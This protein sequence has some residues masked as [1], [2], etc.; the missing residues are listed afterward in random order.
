M[1][2]PRCLM[3]GFLA[4]VLAGTLMGQDVPVWK[5]GVASEIVTP[6]QPM[7]MAGYASRDKP[8]EGKVHDL[9]VKALALESSD[10][11]RIVIVTSDLISVPR[12]IRDA[13]EKV[14]DEKY[15]LPPEGLLINCSH[16]HCGPEIRTTRWSLDGLPP[17][18]LEVAS[19]YEIGRAHV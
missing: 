9:F 7:W 6:D 19:Q 12:P 4:W 17:Q 11:T 8:S 16:T 18:R 3:S 13:L 1:T 14:A 10:G 15:A 2:Q 5:A